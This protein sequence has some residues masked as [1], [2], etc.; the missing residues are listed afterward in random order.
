MED[1][2]F[3]TVA[4]PIALAVIMSVLGLAL[5]WGGIRAL[6]ALGP[7]SLPRMTR[8]GIDPVVIT[9]AALA[10]LLSVLVFGLLPAIRA[11]RPD[12]MDLLR[13]YM[14]PDTASWH[15]DNQGEWTRHHL[16]EDGQDLADIQSWLL[17]SRS[18]QRSSGLR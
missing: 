15:L 18:R 3:A 17:N 9:F 8:V 2:V 4:L 5:T 14:D 13:R 12:V 7:E 1:S 10:G 11:S 16:A 6:L